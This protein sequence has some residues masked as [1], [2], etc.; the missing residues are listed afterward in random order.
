[1]AAADING[2]IVKSC[3]TVLRDTT[4][5][6]GA[7]RSVDANYS[8]YW[9]KGY[10]CPCLGN[11]EIG[12]PCSVVFMDNVSTHMNEEVE[13]AIKSTGAT[14]IYGVLCSS[15]YSLYKAYLKKECNYV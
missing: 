9:V 13:A 1:M 6:E 11:Y 15:H 2:F 4:S 3:C 12:E 5:L 8:L 14:L 7:A 10:L